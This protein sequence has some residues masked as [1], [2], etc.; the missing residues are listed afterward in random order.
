MMNMNR[1]NIWCLNSFLHNNDINQASMETICDSKRSHCW[2]REHTIEYYLG[3]WEKF[4]IK[5][6]VVMIIISFYFIFSITRRLLLELVCSNSYGYKFHHISWKCTDRI[7]FYSSYSKINFHSNLS[8]T[9]PIISLYL[10]FTIQVQLF[11]LIIIYGVPEK[12]VSFMS[13]VSI[14]PQDYVE[15]QQR[16]SRL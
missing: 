1:K 8:T 10:N 2:K 5:L 12:I 16:D 6:I 4:A 11:S 15:C 14:F 13:S 7:P 9:Q 3:H